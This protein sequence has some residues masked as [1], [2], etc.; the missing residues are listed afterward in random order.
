MSVRLT[1]GWLRLSQFARTPRGLVVNRAA[2]A[3]RPAASGLRSPTWWPSTIEQL[4]R[5]SRDSRARGRRCASSLR[6]HA[7][8]RRS[9]CTLGRLV[10]DISTWVGASHL[11]A[12]PAA[13]RTPRS[14]PITR[15]TLGLRRPKRYASAALPSLLRRSL[16][17]EPARSAD[18]LDGYRARRGSAGG[19]ASCEGTAPE[20]ASQVLS[21]R[22]R[23]ACSRRGA[24]CRC[25]RRFGAARPGAAAGIGA[26]ERSTA[27]LSARLDG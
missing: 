4:A 10:L 20:V 14:P 19:P 25:R 21:R 17:I 2:A 27:V 24:C 7:E 6:R 9:A 13:A 8:D 22:V 3:R 5:R 16:T 12:S 26:C 18:W 1:G 15:P 11:L 23:R